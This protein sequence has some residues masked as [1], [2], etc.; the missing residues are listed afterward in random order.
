MAPVCV[1]VC[2][3]VVMAVSLSALRQEEIIK[4]KQALILDNPNYENTI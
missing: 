3:C 1:C 2:V 4:T